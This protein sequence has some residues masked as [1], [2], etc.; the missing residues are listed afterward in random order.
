MRHLVYNVRYSVVPINPSL[1]TITLHSS[2]R[3]TLVYNVT[4]YPFN[5]VITGFEYTSEIFVAQCNDIFK[6]V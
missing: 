3:T 6:I 4:K 1:L 2:V 5:D